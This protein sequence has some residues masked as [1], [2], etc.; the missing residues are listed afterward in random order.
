M[1]LSTGPLNNI[2]T[3]L[4]SNPTITTSGT[5]TNTNTNISSNVT[6]TS[7]S[8]TVNTNTQPSSSSPSPSTK[9]KRNRS[10]G[11]SRINGSLSLNDIIKSLIK[12]RQNGQLF[13]EKP[14]Y[15]YAI[16]ICL[17]ILQSN[18][19]KL[20]LSQIYHW[21]S[22]HFPYFQLKDSSWQNSIRHNLSLNDGFVKTVKS[23]DGK[24]HFW[25]VKE[26]SAQKFFKHE[27]RSYEEIRDKLRNLDQYIF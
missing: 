21:I 5:N 16:L 27:T 8:A 25:Q 10:D 17:A 3:D 18:D 19:G 24:G 12:R 23:S 4:N 26:S 20:T 13:K 15:S 22:S 9:T 14:P 1:T 7:T 2:G 11:C 6:A